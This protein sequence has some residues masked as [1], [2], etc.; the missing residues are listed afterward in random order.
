MTIPH[1]A[2][3][4]TDANGAP[5]FLVPTSNG[6]PFKVDAADL[7]LVPRGPHYWNNTGG[8]R[9]YVS[10]MGQENNIHPARIIAGVGRGKVVRFRDGDRSNLRRNN[11]EVMNG[12]A[13]W[14]DAA[15]VRTDSADQTSTNALRR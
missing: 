6:G 13:K 10:C 3:M 2:I 1:N 9:S 8:G 12:R 15:S 14:S 4:A 11:L 5:I 7:H